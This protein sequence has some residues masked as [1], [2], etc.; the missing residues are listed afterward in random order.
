MPFVRIVSHLSLEQRAMAG[1]R[2]SRGVF[3]PENWTNT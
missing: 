2:M 1:I 3:N